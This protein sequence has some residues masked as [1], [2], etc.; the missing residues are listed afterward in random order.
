MI[1][2]FGLR[3]CPRRSFRGPVARVWVCWYHVGAASG[4]LEAFFGEGEVHGQRQR[5]QSLFEGGLEM[6]GGFGKV[7]L[8]EGSPATSA[9]GSW[10]LATIAKSNLPRLI[11]SVKSR[12]TSASYAT[13][14][15]KDWVQ[16]LPFNMDGRGNLPLHAGDV[17]QEL[18][19]QPRTPGS[20]PVAERARSRIP[21]KAS[22]ALRPH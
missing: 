14:N 4:V 7:F 18:L 9:R 20:F 10:T 13:N 22:P 21:Q 5:D 17:L 11:H 15:P 2:A 1:H 16:C 19:P 6:L 3:Y 8:V 12:G